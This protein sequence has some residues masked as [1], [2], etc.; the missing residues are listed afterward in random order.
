VFELISDVFFVTQNT[1]SRS[2]RRM[3]AE[4]QLRTAVLGLFFKRFSTI[5]LIV[6]LVELGNGFMYAQDRKPAA[7][8]K[9]L[10]FASLGAGVV[11]AVLVLASFGKANATYGPYLEW[12]YDDDS[13]FFPD[14]LDADFETLRRLSGAFD[15]LAWLVSLPLIAYGGVVVHATKGNPFL[16]NVRLS[17]YPGCSRCVPTRLTRPTQS[18]ALFLAITILNFVRLLWFL[19]YAALFLLNPLTV[20]TTPEFSPII[21]GIFDIWIFLIIVVLLFTLAIRKQKG[22]W[23]TPQPWN[24]AI[25]YALAPQ[26]P[27]SMHGQT[28]MPVYGGTP[29]G[30][31]AYQQYGQPTLGQ[32]QQP[33]PGWQPQPVQPQMPVYSQYGPP[34]QQQTNP[35]YAVSH[36]TGSPPPATVP[37]PEPQANGQGPQHELKA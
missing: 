13:S 1:G 9:V 21:D 14:N 11:L 20:G 17:T 4:A 30:G 35:P 29:Y 27:V 16:R 18:A 2:T 31:T 33:P 23:S 5:L 19:I 22:L 7:Y 8:R 3:G 37:A 32:G 28:A 12:I 34:P 24:V 26:Q 25:P 10:F 36:S 6:T 15:I